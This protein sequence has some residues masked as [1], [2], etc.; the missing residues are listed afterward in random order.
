MTCHLT[1]R[2]QNLSA[3]QV[4]ELHDDIEKYLTLEES[5]SN[6]DF[7]TVSALSQIMSP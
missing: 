6:I 4:Y 2:L 5:E 1:Y 7:W 3:E